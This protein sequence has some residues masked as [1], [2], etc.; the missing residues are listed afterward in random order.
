MPQ[1]KVEMSTIAQRDSVATLTQLVKDHDN[2]RE[3]LKAQ[4]FVNVMFLYGNHHFRVT[5]RRGMDNVDDII[6]YEVDKYFARQKI[7]RT[8]NYILPLYRAI[9]SRIIRMKQHIHVEPS[10]SSAEDKDVARVSKECLE[11]VWQNINRNNHWLA[12]EYSGMGS[13]ITRLSTYELVLGNG[14]LEP[15]FNPKTKTM[16]YE[17]SSKNIFESD[18]G[19]VEMRIHHMLNVFKDRYGRYTI[20]RRRISPEQI[21]DE[22]GIDVP[23]DQAEYDNTLDV[24]IERALWGDVYGDRNKQEGVWVYTKYC[25][26]SREYPRGF[27]Y[28]CTE[29]EELFSDDLPQEYKLRDPVT[30]F[31]YQDLGFLGRGQGM[32]EQLV[33]LQQDLNFTRT[34]ISQVKKLMT[35]KLLSPV[36]A[37]LRTQ[38][39]SEVGQIINYNPGF[40]PEYMEPANIAAF[41]EREEDRIM[42]YMEDLANSHDSSMGKD[43]SQVKSGIGIQNLSE[44]DTSMISPELVQMEQKLGYVGELMLDIMEWKYSERR[45]LTISGDDLAGEVKSFIGSDLIGQKRVRVRMGSG[46]PDDIQSR[47]AYI[48]ALASKGYISKD[49]AKE[50]MELGDIDGIWRSLDETGAKTDIMNIVEGNMQVQAQPWEDATTRLK[51]INDYRKGQRYAVLPPEKRQQIDQLADAYQQMLSRELE[52]KVTMEAKQ[53]ALMA[54]AQE[55]AKIPVEQAKAQANKRMTE[56]INYKDLPPDGKLQL[57][58]QAGIKLNPVILAADHVAAHGPVPTPGATAKTGATQ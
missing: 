30:E 23:P 14:Y 50:L 36:G 54:Q 34:R 37:K 38:W 48:D 16:L 53:A 40:K 3:K 10:T 18:V 26:P 20:T 4:A 51:V 52:A 49:R 57:A 2:A 58:A 25:L 8:A 11:D 32:I 56:A 47:A 33:D 21:W 42:R 12:K 22:Y 7:K 43:P 27:K 9:M 31:R 44:V 28:D 5:K 39:D 24:E 17:Q 35:G 15:Y 1:M 6:N 46:M 45:L 41:W 29:K 13:I 55:Q 19:E